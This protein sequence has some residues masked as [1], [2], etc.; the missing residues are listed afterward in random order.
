MRPP[1]IKNLFL[2][3]VFA[4]NTFTTATAQTDKEPKKWQEL[5]NA[6]LIKSPSNDG[7]SFHIKHNGKEKIVRLYL[8]DCPETTLQYVDRNIEQATEFKSSLLKVGT[9][10]ILG[11]KLTEKMLERPFTVITKGEDAQG[12]SNLSRQY[13]I[14]YTSNKKDLGKTLL[15]HGLAR[16]HGI[17]PK[18]H[19]KYDDLRSEYDKIAQKAGK[20]KLGAWGS[21]KIKFP[22]SSIL[23]SADIKEAENQWQNILNNEK[24]KLENIKDFSKEYKKTPKIKKET[25]NKRRGNRE[26]KE[27]E[28]EDYIPKGESIFSKS[29]LFQTINVGSIATNEAHAIK[30]ETDPSITV[31]KAPIEAKLV[32]ALKANPPYQNTLKTLGIPPKGIDL[33]V[34]FQPIVEKIGQ[35]YPSFLGSNYNC[36][37][38]IIRV[39][40]TISEEDLHKVSH[41]I[42]DELGEAN[43]AYMTAEINESL[44]NLYN[45]E[46]ELTRSLYDLEKQIVAAHPNLPS[47]SPMLK[48]KMDNLKELSKRK[49]IEARLALDKLKDITGINKSELS[50]LSSSPQDLGFLLKNSINSS[51]PLKDLTS[52]NTNKFNEHR[53]NTLKK[54]RLA[55][56]K[57]ILSA[58]LQS[59]YTFLA[60]NRLNEYRA[61]S[62]QD[63]YSKI[64][65]IIRNIDLIR[66]QRTELEKKGEILQKIAKVRPPSNIKIILK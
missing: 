58:R 35:K 16:S 32:S 43:H 15:E 18:D 3:L 28:Q 52:L 64:Q 57:A 20:M 59:Q 42:S 9:A 55:I 7:D 27:E 54:D 66:A 11:K 25:D 6:T 38:S 4:T 2:I 40:D 23:S 34:E 33:S 37:V 5:K 49:E 14:V 36:E 21:G 47:S 1:L 10:G 8:V 45:Q 65:E 39:D 24:K 61:M 12:S 19:R 50:S 56:N 63:N 17:S 22:T 26:E 44:A 51:P 60:H 46:S 48:T 62:M 29:I 41:T 53:L 13:A 31:L 30:N